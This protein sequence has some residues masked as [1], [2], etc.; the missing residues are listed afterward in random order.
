MCPFPF[1]AD[2]VSNTKTNR[3]DDAPFNCGGGPFKR[4]LQT[5]ARCDQKARKAG[6]RPEVKA[7]GNFSDLAQTSAM[8]F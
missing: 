1:V 3:Q 7:S 6:L 8:M 4:H 5:L 2:F